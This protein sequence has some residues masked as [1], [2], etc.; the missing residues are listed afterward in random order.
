ME[1]QT[2]RPTAAAATPFFKK[3]TVTVMSLHPRLLLSLIGLAF[4]HSHIG[5]D[6]VIFSLDDG[7]L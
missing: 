6:L 4:I 3:L 5:S 7:L 1:W 2:L